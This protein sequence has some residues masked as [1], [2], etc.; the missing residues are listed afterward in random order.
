[1]KRVRI[2]AIFIPILFFMNTLMAQ[3]FK[4]E[5]D[6]MIPKD[7]QGLQSY[8]WAK[9]G[10]EVLLIG[11]RVDG[12]HLK[13]PFA[14]FNKKYNNTNFIVINLLTQEVWKRSVNDLPPSLSEQ[15]QS[16][17]MEFWQDGNNLILVGGYGYS[18]QKKD[19]I[20][21]PALSIV[22][23]KESIAAVKNAAPLT[24]TVKQMFDE[25]MAVTGGQL[26]KLDDTYLLVGGQR[27]DGR[28][29][30]HGPDHGPGYKQEY[31][32]EIR[33][34]KLNPSNTELKIENYSTIYDTA[35]FHRRD[36]NL[37]PQYNEKGEKIFT[38][39]SGVFRPEIDLP[40]QSLV[41]VSTSGGKMVP[42]FAQHFCHY[43]TASLPI[44][45]KASHTQYTI[46]FGGI[47]QYYKDQS[48]KI[49]KDDDVP[50]TK[51]ISVIER[52]A[53][54]LKEYTLATTMPGYFG[55]SA[56]FIPASEDLFDEH[57]NLKWEAVGENKKLVGYILGGIDSRAPNVFWPG[58][59][60]DSRASP[61][62]WKVFLTKPIK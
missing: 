13:Q 1:M 15:L 48:G 19:H 49:Q 57:E 30:P 52:K 36:Y 56:D 7:F 51:T 37:R 3:N 38:I 9:E 18:E 14:S 2:P 39:F 59:P 41:D 61:V 8:A 54:Q 6:P 12:L 42:G 32:N 34:F 50:F 53:G 26:G 16:S 17:N 40:Y 45:D 24:S 43:H 20:T 55:A 35:L 11:G 4:V 46:F 23:V 31:T 58:G 5:L 47:A 22:K 27:F 21:H 28:Y 10:N 44:Y 33:K 60:D 62:I 25:R 29:N